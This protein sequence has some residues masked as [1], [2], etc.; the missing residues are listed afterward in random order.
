MVSVSYLASHSTFTG[1]NATP[2]MVQTQSYCLFSTS[3][4]S[5][6]GETVLLYFEDPTLLR[7]VT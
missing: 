3:T 2:G 6:C 5:L 1:A 4:P 7:M